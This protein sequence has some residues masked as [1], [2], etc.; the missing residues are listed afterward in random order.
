MKSKRVE[1]SELRTVI[2]QSGNGHLPLSCRVELLQS[3]GNVEIVNKV[4]AECCKKVYP[5][6]ANEIE[7]TL[8]RK[9]L[10]SADEYLYHGKGKADALV[11]E[12]NRLRN[13]VEGQSCTESMAGWAVISLCYSIADHAAA[14]L[15][16]D[17][18]E[19]EDDGA[20]EYEVWNTD[21][22][23]SMAF[24]GG[25]PFVD[26]GDAGKRWEF[27]NWYLD[28]VETL[29]RKSDA[30]LI[31]IDAPKKK[32]VEQN[33][34]PQ[35][36]QTYQTPDILLKIQ[37][38]IEKSMKVFNDYCT[39][40]WDRIIVEAYCIGDVRTEGYFICNNIVSKMPVS[41]STAD[42][43]SEIKNDMYKQASIEGAWLMCKIVFDTQKKF[44]I[45]FNYDNKASLP[46]D[47][48]D[49]PERLEMAFKKSPRGKDYTP[50]WWQEILGKKAKYLKNTI[51]VEQ[52]AIP[53][54]TQTYQTP[55]IQEKIRQVIENSMKVFNKYCTGNWSKIVVEA[56]CIGDVR[57]KGYFIQ[58]NSTTEMPVSLA[59]SD[60]LS[61]IKDDM[62]KQASNEGSWLICKIEFDTQ[63]KFIIEFNYDN[64][65]SLPNDVFDNP[66]RLE[67]EFEDYPRT[68]EYTPVWWQGI[69]GKKVK[70]LE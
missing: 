62:Y 67:T 59:A 44:I 41:L 60:L 11:E 6:W 25:N 64:K 24:A 52:L 53:Q 2:E 30:P 65:S 1:I 21:F 54:R 51:I 55:A 13:Y 31:R 23:A 16:I 22:F 7:D 58:G 50:V 27:W 18:Y 61:E 34:I 39:G 35:R 19:G 68:K 69:L 70:Y 38:I 14:M 26:E 9:L 29:C 33:T 42:L 12:A 56:H 28:T 63:K 3:I 10:C 57:T 36:T 17:E 32:E 20:F 46:N 48:F 5:L 40:N 8:L 45:E 37:Q 43:L 49:N 15:D 4:F 66:E 47:V